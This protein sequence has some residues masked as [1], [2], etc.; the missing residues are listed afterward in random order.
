MMQAPSPFAP[1]VLLV[2]DDEALREVIAGA[3]DMAGSQVC[4]VPSGEAAIEALNAA[5]Y[6]LVLLDVG[7]PGISGF[8]TLRQI[9][10][11]GYTPVIMVTGAA[12]LDERLLGFDLGA[13][14]YVAK[15]LAPPELD[16][17]IRAVLRRVRNANSFGAQVFGP[18]R[19]VLDISA[20]TLHAGDVEVSLSRK[21]FDIFRL[22]L[23][24]RGNVF[25]PDE[26]SMAVWG[27]GTFGS[28]NFV[29]AQ[30][31]RIRASLAAAGADG[32]L[33]TVRGAGYVIR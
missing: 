31:S 25:S 29:E 8:E 11:R 27:Y 7:L 2:D 33:L 4:S 23:E 21:Q 9:R 18:S 15:P 30:I 19:I 1:R 24:R 20:L 12:S 22:L 26:I 16:R 13:D 3:L 10:L 17:R 32:V 14:D 28:P 6:D 5:E